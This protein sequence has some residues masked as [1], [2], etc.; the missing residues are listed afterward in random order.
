[1]ERWEY[2][3]QTVTAERGYLLEMDQEELNK[4][5]DQGWELIQVLSLN[6]EKIAG[7]ANEG[8]IMVQCQMIFKRRKLNHRV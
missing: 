2:L 8:F 5:G 1:M 6:S 7:L 4:L 3:T